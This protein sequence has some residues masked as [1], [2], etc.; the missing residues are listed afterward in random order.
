V[1]D[2][3]NTCTRG[4]NNVK[5]H[6]MSSRSYFLI[7]ICIARSRVQIL[8]PGNQI[9][10]DSLRIAIQSDQEELV[11]E[12]FTDGRRLIKDRVGELTPGR[13]QWSLLTVE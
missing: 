11:L 2:R 9:N 10:F 13:G 7:L 12:E 1:T 4:K 3:L 6:T 8:T 5:R